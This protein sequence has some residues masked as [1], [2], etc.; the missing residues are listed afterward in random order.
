MGHNPNF[1]I[2][3][4]NNLREI[5]GGIDYINKYL[6]MGDQLQFLTIEISALPFN[7]R[8]KWQEYFNK[9]QNAMDNLV[10][11]LYQ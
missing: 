3:M 1:Q 9:L 2:S 6:N 8:A 7:G 11:E 5:I 4:Y 10:K